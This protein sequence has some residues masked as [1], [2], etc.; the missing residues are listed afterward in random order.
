MNYW[1]LLIILLLLS[2]FFLKKDRFQYTSP[3]IKRPT[4]EQDILDK[5]WEL[6]YLNKPKMADVNRILAVDPGW[7]WQLFT[8][9]ELAKMRS[10]F[11][12]E[13][14]K[15]IFDNWSDQTYSDLVSLLQDR[16][17]IPSIKNLI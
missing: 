5:L 6:G 11:T 2:I 9:L 16:W 10:N 3:S 8:E 12:D 17:M 1:I 7:G 4:T 14:W 13:E 15:Y